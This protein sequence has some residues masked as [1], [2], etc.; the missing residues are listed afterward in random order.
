MHFKAMMGA[1]GAVAAAVAAVFTFLASSGKA[2]KPP[3]ADPGVAIG[4]VNGDVR[5]NEH[6]APPPATSSPPPEEPT[7]EPTDEPT[8]EP[9]EEPTGE[10]EEESPEPESA[11]TGT[12]VVMAPPGYT[13]LTVF[14]R[15]TTLSPP[16]GSVPVGSTVTI[17]C[18][19]RGQTWIDGNG[20]PSNLWN[21]VPGG[22]V[23]DAM[24]DT[25][26]GDPVAPPC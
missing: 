24:I 6:P 9:A 18:T 19:V 4:T 16:A 21:H 25:G 20:N 15:P 2:E 14:S 10:P 13:S 5:I 12:G 17:D 1:L 7:G 22:F 23:P 8:E 3:P 26:T 11:P